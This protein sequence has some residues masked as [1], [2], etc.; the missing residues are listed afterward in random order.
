MMPFPLIPLL[1]A[2]IPAVVGAAGSALGPKSADQ[3]RAKLAKLVAKY[4][5]AKGA[6]K[7]DKLLSKIEALSGTLRE[8][9]ET[10]QPTVPPPDVEDP[11]PYYAVSAVLLLAGGVWIVHKRSKR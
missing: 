11:T 10:G 7:R 6:K 8:A 4:Q 2:A 5:R 3:Q 1:A 9:E